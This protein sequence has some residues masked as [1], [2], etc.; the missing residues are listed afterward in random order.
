MSRN[1]QPSFILEKLLTPDEVLHMPEH[2]RVVYIRNLTLK[3]YSALVAEVMVR[4]LNDPLS[5][6]RSN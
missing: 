4:N 5:H 2:V 3:Q 1:N 6:D